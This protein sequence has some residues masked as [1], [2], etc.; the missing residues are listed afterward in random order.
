M[1]LSL[2]RQLP[3]TLSFLNFIFI[4][5]LNSHFPRSINPC[6]RGGGR[7]PGFLCGLIFVFGVLRPGSLRKPD[8]EG[9]PGGDCKG[10]T[11]MRY[12]YPEAGGMSQPQRAAGQPLPFTTEKTPGLG[13]NPGFQIVRRPCYHGATA[14]PQSPLINLTSYISK[15]EDA[16]FNRPP[17]G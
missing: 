11:N 9:F 15:I 13:S 6:A 1:L 2:F 17:Y 14:R 5:F 7:R 10:R 4:L 8:G 16:Y 12:P 3:L